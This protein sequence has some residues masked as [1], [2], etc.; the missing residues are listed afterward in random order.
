MAIGFFQRISGV[1]E[2]RRRTT[3][4]GEQLEDAERVFALVNGRIHV[5]RIVDLSLLG[6]FDAVRLLADLRRCEVIEP[7]R[8]LKFD[9]Y[10]SKWQRTHDCGNQ[11]TATN[12]GE[13]LKL[14]Q[15]A[16]AEVS[17]AN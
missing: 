17:P 2:Y 9:Q 5:R 11:R 16:Q 7:L 6:S 8:A 3:L 4:Q 10:P 13:G 15:V 1:E 12:Q 14:H